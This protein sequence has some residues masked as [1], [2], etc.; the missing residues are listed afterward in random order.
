MLNAESRKLFEEKYKALC[1]EE[2]YWS[3]IDAGSMTNLLNRIKFSREKKGLSVDDDGLLD[4]L[5]LFIDYIKDAF[6]LNHFNVSMLVNQYNS[7]M[8]GQNNKDFLPGQH[9]TRKHGDY[10][11][12]NFWEDG[13]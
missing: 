9:L 8:T 6:V 13:K 7:I 12:E 2:Y 5:R 1:G 11:T 10:N 4:G 3:K